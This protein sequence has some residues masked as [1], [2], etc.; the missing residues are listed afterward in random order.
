M[1]VDGSKEYKKSARGKVDMDK[2]QGAIELS[3]RTTAGTL[4]GQGATEYLVLLAVV[5]IVAL[6]SVALLGFFPGM[7]N[8]AQYTQSQAYWQSVQPISISELGPAYAYATLPTG[9][10]TNTYFRIRNS[11][12]YR[13]RLE[14]MLGGGNTQNTYYNYPASRSD[15]WGNITLSPGEEACIGSGYLPNDPCREHHVEFYQTGGPTN[16]AAQLCNADGTGMLK[17]NGFGFE[18]TE[19]IDGQQ[20]TKREIGTA[21]FM[22][23]CVG[24]SS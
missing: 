5:L 3:S 24:K 20:I 11:G 9:I 8:D 7:A 22:L 4:V 18:Y 13:I 16:L 12:Q 10:P 17:V 2:A 19:F 23:K 6:V 21:S 1:M 14:K 15:G